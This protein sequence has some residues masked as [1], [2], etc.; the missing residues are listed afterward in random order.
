[1]LQ[2]YLKL[3]LFHKRLKSDWIFSI[4]LIA[5]LLQIVCISGKEF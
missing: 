1:M 5:N 3:T 2:R 4:V